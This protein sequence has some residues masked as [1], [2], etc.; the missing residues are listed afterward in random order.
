MAAITNYGLAGNPYIDGLLTGVKWANPSLTYSF[1][2]S[3]SFYSGYPTNEPHDNFLAFTAVQ[4]QAIAKVLQNYS[5]VS[6]L[7]FTPMTESANSSATI[8]YAETDA[9]STAWSYYPNTSA[10]GGDSWFN[11]SNHY[12]DN[13]QIGNYAYDLMLHETGHTIG[14]KHPQDTVGAFG[15]LPSDHDA[16]PYTV[17][18]YRSYVGGPLSYSVSAASYPETLMMDDI[19]AVQ[20]LYGANY[21]TNSG[22]TVYRWSPT[23][24]AETINGVAQ[25]SPAANKIFMTVWDGGGTDTYD[26]SNYT[27]G[28]NVD[29]NP[30]GWTTTC[31]AQLANLGSGHYAPGNIANAYL[32]QGNTASLIENAIGGSGNDVLTGNQANNQLTGGPGNDILNG[33][34]G[35]DTAVYS[36]V[37]SNYSWKQNSDATWTVTDLRP[38]SPDGTDR[39]VGIEKLQFSDTTVTLSG[40]TSTDTYPVITSAAPSATLTEWTDGSTNEK[41]NVAHKASGT[42]TF[43]D[44]DTTD[45]HVASFVA[46]AKGYVGAFNLGTLDNGTDSV[47]WSFSVADS[48][49]DFLTAGQTL[50]QKY[51]VTINDGHGGT[52]VQTVTITLV[53][54]NDAA[55]PVTATATGAA[56]QGPASTHSQIDLATND[57]APLPAHHDPVFSNVHPH[58]ELAIPTHAEFYD[59]GL[60]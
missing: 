9:T 37:A 60:I 32:F 11:N 29:L 24:G 8:R 46:E 15:L 21:A 36:G 19:R 14:L 28:V 33:G 44:P 45:A 1:P 38:G 40:I 59:S 54:K 49:I 31:S 35:T 55:A 13:P 52:A 22:N 2:S 30:G 27:T 48:A 58:D 43:W 26:F 25:P 16:L 56:G 47:P 12:Y 18:S 50:T 42:I 5:A 4:Q 20:T 7:Q 51:D 53:G 6:N 3:S 23:T 39:L 34:S 41:N 10:Q 57:E 17:M